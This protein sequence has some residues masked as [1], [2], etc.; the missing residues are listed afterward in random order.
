MNTIRRKLIDI[1]EDILSAL[2]YQATVANISVKKLIE[3]WVVKCS[4]MEEDK[5][6]KILSSTPEANDF[7]SAEESEEFINSLKG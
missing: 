4:E 7:L 6:L 5:L 1:P 3:I 2:K